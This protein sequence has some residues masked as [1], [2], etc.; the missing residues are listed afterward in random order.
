MN[1]FLANIAEQLIAQYPKGMDKVAVVL[2]SRRAIVFLKHYLSLKIKQPIWLPKFY[3]IEDFIAELS[4]LKVLDNLSLQFRLYQ[5]YLENTPKEDCD[6]LEHFL[7]WSQTLLYD[8]NEIDRYLVDAKKL[9]PNLTGLKEMEQWSLGEPD[10]TPFQEKY[11][12]FFEHMYTWYDAFQSDLLNDGVAYQG[13]A[14]RKAAEQIEVSELAFE[15]AWFVGLN[16]LT[17]AE[18]RIINHL[19]SKKKAQLFWDADEHYVNN[20]DHESGLFLRQHFEEWG[21]QKC[22]DFFTQNKNIEVIGCAK[23]VGQARV[24]GD[25]LTHLDSQE[26]EQNQTALVM[27]DEQLLFPV[28]NNLPA[29]L[30]SVNITMGAPL[31]STP[32]FSLIDLLFKLHLRKEQYQQKAFY[33][34]DIQKLLRHP[35]LNK[36]LNKGMCV[37]LHKQMVERNVVFANS[38][39]LE[40]MLEGKFPEDWKTLSEILE[41]WNTPEEMLKGVLGLLNHFKETLVEEKATVESEVLFSFYKSIQ[42]LQNHL[43]VFPEPINLKTLR[44]IFFQIIGKEAIPFRGEPLNGLQMMGVLETRTLDFKNVVLM[45]VNEEKLPSGKSV[46]SFVPFVLK[47]YFK[48][49]THEE[50]DAV[51]SYHFYRLLQRAENVYLLYNSQNDDFG[52]GEKSRFITQIFHE[53]KHLNPTEKLLQTDV[54]K[55]EGVSEINIAKTVDVQER[56]KA[57]ASGKVSPS[58]LNTYINC[59]LQFYFQYIA[60]IREL[61][62]VEEFIEASSFGTVIH[63]AL[64]DAYKPHLGKFLTIDLLQNIEEKAY[65]FIA[66]GFENKFGDSIQFGKNHLIWKVSLQ[67]TKTFFEG[68]YKLLAALKQEGKDLRLTEL[69]KELEVSVRVNG[70]DFNLFGKVDRVD[71]TGDRLRIVDYKTGKVEDKDLNIDKWEDLITKRTKSK[72]FQLMTYAYLYLK[73]NEVHSTEVIAGNYSFKNLQNGLVE[74]KK[75]KSKNPM[76]IDAFV[77]SEYENVLTQLLEEISDMKCDFSQAEELAACQWCDFKSVCGR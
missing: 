34:R 5:V 72:A 44:S 62:E 74:I 56:I 43:E 35:Y 52:S 65:Q 3:S 14:Y 66:E 6:D 53:L 17:T 49:P 58:A 20:K 26:V 9:L 41:N 38:Q 39:R 2:P 13:L 31:N 54:N 71:F 69:E 29:D 60:K 25:I 1:A 50:R 45:S 15:E 68:E 57:W 75:P 12:R 37:Y 28:L 51:F 48:M 64:E 42:Q 27:A 21:A 22:S 23:N 7:K 8:F 32:L 76:I 10:L 40:K 55:V 47:K 67:L 73:K 77:L 24:A 4:G 16:A 19:L 33:F 30:K 70:Y 59:P 18:K 36:L 61:N 11:V 46:N 63:D